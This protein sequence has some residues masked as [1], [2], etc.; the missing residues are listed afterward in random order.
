MLKYIPTSLII[1]ALYVGFVVAGGVPLLA[2]IPVAVKWVAIL[3][4]IFSALTLLG[5]IVLLIGERKNEKEF[6]KT[7]AQFVFFLIFTPFYLGLLTCAVWLPAYQNLVVVAGAWIIYTIKSSINR[8][9]NES[10][11]P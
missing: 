6:E 3:S 7:V 2:A 5:T 1:G 8:L 11:K 4:W 10:Y 9:I